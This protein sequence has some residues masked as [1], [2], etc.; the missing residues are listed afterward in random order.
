MEN[1]LIDI[2]L[3]LSQRVFYQNQT[4]YQILIATFVDMMEWENKPSHANVPSIEKQT[5]NS[6]SGSGHG[7]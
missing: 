3:S 6:L 2:K 4:K 7:S 5:R 1:T